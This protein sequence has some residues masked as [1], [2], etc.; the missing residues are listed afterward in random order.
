MTGRNRLREVSVPLLGLSFLLGGF[1]LLLF[2][3]AFFGL[4][5]ASGFLSFLFIAIGTILIIRTSP[6]L[7]RPTPS[8]GENHDLSR[9]RMDE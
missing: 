2:W 9:L 4:G 6:S 3:N 1:L 7:N 8:P 5:L